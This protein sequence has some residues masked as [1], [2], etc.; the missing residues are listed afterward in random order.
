[1]VY[2]SVIP[3]ATWY[4]PLYNTFQMVQIVDQDVWRSSA[5]SQAL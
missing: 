1:M 4:E 2:N 5:N 3:E